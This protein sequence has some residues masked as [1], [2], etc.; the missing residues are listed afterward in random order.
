MRR[1]IR[2]KVLGF[3]L[4]TLALVLAAG[5]SG[6]GWYYSGV[7][8]DGALRPDYDD[9]VFDMEIVAIDEGTI[10]LRPGPESDDDGP[11]TEDG[12]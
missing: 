10:T 12:I 1:L 6:G 3:A 7:L 2:W 11:W 8:E 4:L 5:L 9:P